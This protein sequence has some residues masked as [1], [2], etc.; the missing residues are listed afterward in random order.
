MKVKEAFDAVNKD[1]IVF[2]KHDHWELR[3]GL[4]LIKQGL[5]SVISGIRYWVRWA[6]A[7]CA[8]P[9]LPILYPIAIIIR[10][11]KK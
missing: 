1:L 4:D 8:I 3:V 6:F 5:L 2:L 7:L 10:V 11:M 9:L